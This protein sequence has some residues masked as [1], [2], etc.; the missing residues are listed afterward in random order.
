MESKLYAEFRAEA[1]HGERLPVAIPSDDGVYVRY[2]RAASW[3]SV[4]SEDQD[5]M[6]GCIVACTIYTHN[7]LEGYEP[8]ATDTAEA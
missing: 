1:E 8:G 4:Y 3:S 2:Y 5:E 7:E 6:I